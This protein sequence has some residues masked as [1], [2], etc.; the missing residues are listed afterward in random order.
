MRKSRMGDLI[1]QVDE[2]SPELSPELEAEAERDGRLAEELAKKLRGE[3][4]LP[5]LAKHASARPE[6]AGLTLLQLAA[7]H[8]M[9]AFGMSPDDFA[10]FAHRVAELHEDQARAIRNEVREGTPRAKAA[11]AVAEAVVAAAQKETHVQTQ[12]RLVLERQCREIA[13]KLK[14]WTPAG[15]GFALFLADYG[16]KGNT[17]YVSTVGREGMIKLVREWLDRQEGA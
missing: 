15:V 13:D 17:A 12:V 7:V 9:A 14:A 5:F 1:R 6:V 8:L 2:L 16:E 10:D 3:V 4:L 11:A